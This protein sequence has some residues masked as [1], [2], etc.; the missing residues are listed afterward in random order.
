[1]AIFCFRLRIWASRGV[2]LSSWQSW[3]LCKQ[4]TTG[5]NH[6]QQICHYKRKEIFTHKRA[7]ETSF[8]KCLVSKYIYMRLIQLPFDVELEERQ[9][10]FG[11]DYNLVSPDYLIFAPACSQTS[12]HIL[13]PSETAGKITL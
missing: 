4:A 9:T 1:M 7:E 3:Q 8:L 2:Y 12:K 10:V 13:F 11:E 6:K 5:G